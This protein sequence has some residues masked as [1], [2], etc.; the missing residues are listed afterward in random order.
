MLGI[1]HIYFRPYFNG[2]IPL[3]N[4]RP[5]TYIIEN[6]LV[7]AIFNVPFRAILHAWFIYNLY[8]S[9]RNIFRRVPI[10]G[11]LLRYLYSLGSTV[12]DW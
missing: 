9:F 11:L 10:T 1:L 4:I 12:Y 7:D 8:F 5:V 2:F 6:G 3:L